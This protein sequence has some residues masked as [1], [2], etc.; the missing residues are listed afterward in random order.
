VSAP[1]RWFALGPPG[2]GITAT[3]SA[4]SGAPDPN[5]AGALHLNMSTGD[6]SKWSGSAWSVVGNLTGP[7]GA[8]GDLTEASLVSKLSDSESDVREALDPLY[9]GGGAWGEIGGDITDQDDLADALGE[10]VDAAGLDSAVAANIST[11]SL[12][13]PTATDTAIYGLFGLIWAALAITQDS[14]PDGDD[15]VRYPVADREKVSDAVTKAMTSTADIGFVIDEDSMA[16]DSATKVPT[17]QS[18][19]AYVD[20]HSGGVTSVAGKTGPDISLELSD[21][22]DYDDLTDLLTSVTDGRITGYLHG[23]ATALGQDHMS[24][25]Q[26]AAVTEAVTNRVYMV[27]ED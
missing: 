22:S 9:A 1:D 4:P 24:Q 20:A 26:W 15:Y 14:I 16:T 7:A 25:T 18:V 10:K 12:D 11:T 3:S 5:V 23:V 13:T 17:Q 19:K 8:A 2:A 21:L 27:Y 6:V